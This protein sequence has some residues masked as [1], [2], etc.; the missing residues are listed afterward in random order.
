M[1]N[2]DTPMN[3][4]SQNDH[5]PE[6][7]QD[8]QN[9]DESTPDSGGSAWLERAEQLTESA[10]AFG[11]N[12]THK[13]RT[14]ISPKQLA[15]GVV[16]MT[17][18]EGIG[19]AVGGVIGSVGGPI[20][21]V[22]G[23]QLGS[24]A[25][26]SMGAKYGYEWRNPSETDAS[27][28]DENTGHDA[29]SSET[30]SSLHQTLTHQ[31]A[32]L[33]GENLGKQAGAALGQ[34]VGGPTTSQ[35]MGTLG[36]TL[37]G[38]MGDESVKPPENAGNAKGY[39]KAPTRAWLKKMAKTKLTETALSGILGGVGQWV[40]GPIGGR[41]GSKAGAIASSHLDWSKENEPEFIDLD[42]KESQEKNAAT[43]ETLDQ[44]KKAK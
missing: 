43:V 8:A 33:A 9:P 15:T 30:P 40:L 29:A 44:E 35:I 20:G 5:E 25:G 38:A 4:Q 6:P 1:I 7:I 24:M 32:H 17:A 27:I 19:S 39:R 23:A 22:I 31:S 41:I 34:A 3:E 13:I 12:V 11:Q 2:S 14:N 26:G 42:S 21:T 16:G 37:G 28:D 10:L 18:G 36:E